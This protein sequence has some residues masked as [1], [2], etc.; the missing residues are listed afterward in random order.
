[1]NE[2]HKTAT[3]PTIFHEVLNSDLPAEEKTDAR[4]GDEAQLIVAAGLITTS[5]ALTVGS[6]HIINDPTI[7]QKLR[8]ELKTAQ[9]TSAAP[10]DWHKLEQLP[11]LNGCVH[12]AMRLAHG[13]VTRSPLLAPDTELKYGPWTIPRNTPVSM[14]SVDILMNEKL[15]PNPRAFVPERWINEP[16]LDRYFV[17]FGKGSRQCLGIK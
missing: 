2:A 17:P 9:S 12:E 6:F 1:M 15:F 5:W 8:D 16:D 13:V 11:Y 4:L 14:T 7:N 3:H 10:L